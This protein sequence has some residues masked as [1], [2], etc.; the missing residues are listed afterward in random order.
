MSSAPQETPF[1]VWTCG[2]EKLNGGMELK[3]L[4]V[5]AKFEL[6]CHGDIPVNAW[7]AKATPTVAFKQEQ[8]AYS[9]V[10]LKT[11][12]LDAQDARFV[13]TGYKPGNHQPEFFRIVQGDKGFEAAKPTWE[14]KSVL[15]PNQQPP[16]QPY[17]PF[18]PFTVSMPPWLWIGALLLFVLLIAGVVQKLRRVRQRRRMLEELKRH[19]T[20]MSPLHQFYRDSRN[21]RRRLHSVKV[22][23]ELKGIS[24]DLNREFRL[25]LLRQFEIP[26]LEWNDAAILRDLRKR[27][28]HVFIHAG[29]PLKK[30]LRELLR[31]QARAR[32][33]LEDVEQL[34]RMSLD[35]AE[36]IESARQ[37][38][39]GP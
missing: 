19:R 35:A 20:P 6:H 31:T 1:P 24:S 2:F 12:Q 15:P 10:I 32:I 8:D 28:R 7:D 5:G 25:Y 27:H 29:A 36:R 11:E 17:G 21:L 13:V 34:H 16:P 18:G 9:L 39:A 3:D 22:E 14:I 38:E 30:T 23:D 4:T 33:S 37:K 26:T